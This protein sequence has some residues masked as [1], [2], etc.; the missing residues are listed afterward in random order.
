MPLG[1][2]NKPQIISQSVH[3]AERTRLSRNE[4]VASFKDNI[5]S[6]D[7]LTSSKV[8]FVYSMNSLQ[9]SYDDEIQLHVEIFMEAIFRGNTTSYTLITENNGSFC[10]MC[11]LLKQAYIDF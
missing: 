4:E 8:I 1:D 11:D 5:L 2:P 9:D 6:A 3:F 10:A 7:N